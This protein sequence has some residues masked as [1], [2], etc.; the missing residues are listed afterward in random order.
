MP[1]RSKRP[2]APRHLPLLV[3]MTSVCGFVATDIF[4]PAIP[5]LSLAY[6]RDATQIQAMF[7]VFLYALAV[8]QL[9]HGPL[10]DVLG[11][12]IPLL[13][14]LAAYSIA[15]LAIP[16]TDRYE[17]VL[18]WRV[19]QGVG[20]C[21]AIVVGRAV[22]ADFHRGDALRDFFLGVS[23][24]V[25]MSPALAPVLGQQL[26]SA[27][28]WQACFVFTAAFG[29]LL[30]LLVYAGLPESR[31]AAA[32]AGVGVRHALTAYAQVLRAPGFLLNT[33]IIAVAQAA[34]FAYLSESTFLLLRQGVP[35][36]ALGYAYISLAAAYVAGNTVARVL[37]PRVGSPALYRHGSLLFLCA[38]IALGVGLPLLPASTALLLAGVS[39]LTFANGFLLPLGTA[40]A[41]GAARAHTASASGLAGFLQLSCAALAA[42][43]IGPLTSHRPAA[44]G[45]VMLGLGM[46]NFALYLALRKRLA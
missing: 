33:A 46:A 11:R 8:S 4:L 14:S 17:A 28:G 15:S 42:Q 36:S 27:L 1:W 18:L 24:F 34:Y 38:G 23:I 32:A 25:G 9:V 31:D 26:Y 37:A 2:A 20:A 40:A 30:G 12:R 3:A 29:A 19:V 21:G 16:W 7:S 43:A 45:G 5:A 35:A 39:V 10:S 44:F 22:A 13:A 6:E 41:V